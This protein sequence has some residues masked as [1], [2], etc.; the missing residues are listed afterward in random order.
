MNQILF[1]VARKFTKLPP[2]YLHW[3]MIWFGKKLDESYHPLFDRKLKKF[4]VQVMSLNPDFTFDDKIS[5]QHSVVNSKGEILALTH[6][7]RTPR[8]L[9]LFKDSGESRTLCE[10]PEQDHALDWHVHAMNIDAED[11]IHLI[12]I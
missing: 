1:E 5:F 10:A 3:P 12:I 11:N 8:C 9:K 4:G 7:E 2:M 6:R